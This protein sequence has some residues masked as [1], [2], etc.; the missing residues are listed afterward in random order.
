MLTRR[1]KSVYNASDLW[2]IEDDELF[3]K[4]CTNNRLKCYN[5]I[6]RDTSARPH[7]LTTLKIKDVK[8]RQNPDGT[9]FVQ[10]PVNGKTGDRFLP[11]FNSIPHVKFWLANCHSNPNN[12]DAPFLCQKSGKAILP[13]QPR[14]D[15]ANQKLH[16][17][18][19]LD[20]PDVPSEDRDKI[21][22]LLAKPWHGYIRR[23]TG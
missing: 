7:E 20:S 1:E 11:L 18:K 13:N 10:V 5:A 23:H 3:M 17:I 2:S 4:Y 19:L 14:R 16:F 21:K 6:S 15:Y 22:L 12:P 9:Q 8:F